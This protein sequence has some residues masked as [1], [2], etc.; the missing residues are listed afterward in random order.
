MVPL[1]IPMVPEHKSS[2]EDANLKEG[3]MG[4]RIF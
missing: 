2:I 4:R 3:T 1:V